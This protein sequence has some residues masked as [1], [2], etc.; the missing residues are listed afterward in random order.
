M[1]LQSFAL[2][3][4][5]GAQGVYVAQNGG[6]APRA[7]KKS[8][9]RPANRPRGGLT[10]DVDMFALFADCATE[11]DGSFSFEREEVAMD[12]GIE[13]WL[14]AYFTEED[15]RKGRVV[16]PTGGGNGFLGGMSV[17]LARGK[18]VVEAAAWGSVAASFMIEQVG[19]PVLGREVEVDVTGAKGEK[20]GEREVWNGESVEERLE[21]FR[22]RCGPW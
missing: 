11:E 4:R 13:R 14:P 15:A 2:V 18:G 6:R 10:L 7:R 20:V 22:E 5:C 16:D 3:V 17:A 9:K 19:V 21:K 12:P 8:S 1:P